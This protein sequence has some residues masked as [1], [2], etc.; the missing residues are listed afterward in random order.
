MAKLVAVGDTSKF[1][2]GTMREVQVG[3]KS[4]LVIRQ[5]DDFYALENKCSQY[6]LS[7]GF[8][9]E[10]RIACSMH[11]SEFNLKTGEALSLP[12]YEN[13][14]AYPVQVNNGHIEVEID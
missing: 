6:P 3:K 9:E 14:K 5:G 7:D 4:I 13:V 1:A 10:D 8:L 2:P 11:G 12:A